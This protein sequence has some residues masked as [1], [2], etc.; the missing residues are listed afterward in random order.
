MQKKNELPADPPI[1]LRKYN[2]FLE[3]KHQKEYLEFPPEYLFAS[4]NLEI[5]HLDP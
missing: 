5:S 2:V 4:F 3:G 1:F